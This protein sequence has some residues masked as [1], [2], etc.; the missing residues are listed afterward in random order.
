MDSGLC[1]CLSAEGPHLL[2]T[3][4]NFL[5]HSDDPKSH[6]IPA[7]RS[8][9]LLST[10]YVLS[11]ALGA[12]HRTQAGRP[13]RE[14]GLFSERARL[15]RELLTPGRPRRG[16]LLCHLRTKASFSQGLAQ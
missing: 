6:H 13:A 16:H 7:P 10:Y 14:S 3:R 11:M 9:I 1:H 15:S 2:G 8:S 12:S 5:E 4:V